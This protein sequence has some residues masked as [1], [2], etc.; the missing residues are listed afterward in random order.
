MKNLGTLKVTTPSDTEIAMTRV[1]DAPC[2]L[3]FEALTRP[4]LVKRWYGPHGH[5]LV[6]CEIDFRVGGKWRYVLRDPEG[7]DM[8]QHGTYLEIDAPDRIVNTEGFDDFPGE[9]MVTTVLVERDGKTTMTATVRSPSKEVRDIMLAT[10]M[11]HGAAETYDRLAELL[12]ST[13]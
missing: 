4:E 13:P 1:F 7:Q 6:V 9:A 5:H 8:G 3:V 2:R 11:E 12:Q 10:G